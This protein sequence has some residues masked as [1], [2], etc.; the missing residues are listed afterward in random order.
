MLTRLA[1]LVLAFFVFTPPGVADV[2]PRPAL[3][4]PLASKVVFLG[5][6]TAGDRVVAVGERGVIVHSDDLGVTWV[7]ADVPVRAT[8]TAVTFVDATNGFAVGHDAVVLKTSDGGASWSVLNFEP[9]SQVMLLNVRFQDSRHG[10]AVGSNGQLWRTADGGS[11][12]ERTTL[13]VED[14][15]QNHI[16]DIAWRADGATL[17]VAEKGVLYRS[18]DGIAGFAP[19]PSPYEGSWFGAL[20]LRDGV[21]LIYGM[22]GHVFKSTD[23]GDT[24]AQIPTNTE[25]FLLDADILP[26]GRA[27]IVGAGGTLVTLDDASVTAKVITRPDGVGINAV[28][29]VGNDVYLADLGGGIKRIAL[30][31]LLSR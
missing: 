18:Q 24:W 30:A 2:A 8:L 27:L 11:A 16:F 10:Y 26:D 9:D 29:I 1:G 5:M 17:A 6:A 12:W 25:Q 14:W 23:R 28:L 19:I 20:T 13:A 22:K 4:V 21:F 3:H 7:Q 15:Y 31:D